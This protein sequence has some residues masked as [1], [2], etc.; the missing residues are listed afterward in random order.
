MV[1]VFDLSKPD[2]LTEGCDAVY[3][4]DYDLYNTNVFGLVVDATDIGVQTGT[5]FSY[6]VTVCDKSYEVPQ[7][8]GAGAL[9]EATGTYPATFAPTDPPVL[10]DPLVCGGFFAQ[11]CSTM[12]VQRSGASPLQ[13]LLLIYPNNRAQST[14]EVVAIGG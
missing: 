8:D 4:Q 10:V 5:A 6:G 1:C 9:D 3:S 14:A 13:D 7:C 2:A 12:T 11:E